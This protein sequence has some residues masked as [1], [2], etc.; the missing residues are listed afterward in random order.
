MLLSARRT[1]S[2]PNSL[3][4][5]C[6]RHSGAPDLSSSSASHMA[7]SA[8]PARTRPSSSAS[9]RSPSAECSR[10]VVRSTTVSNTGSRIECAI[11][12]ST[13]RRTLRLSI[14]SRSGSGRC[15][16]NF[17]LER[18]RHP[19]VYCGAGFDGLQPTLPIRSQPQGDVERSQAVIGRVEIDRAQVARHRLAG[20]KV[21]ERRMPSHALQLI[22]GELD[23]EL[24]L[25]FPGKTHPQTP[26]RTTD[27]ATICP[28]H[29][30]SP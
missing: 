16:G 24:Q 6:S 2:A 25:A 30:A 8:L 28:A 10:R 14:S 9:S 7:S 19:F 13:L 15:D 3:A 1:G 12:F 27:S 29:G 17:H 22:A 5:V 23:L 11:A 18:V 4:A 20:G 21:A 26:T